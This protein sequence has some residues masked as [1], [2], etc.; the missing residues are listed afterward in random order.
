M[1]RNGIG[2]S[3]PQLLMYSAIGAAAG[4]IG[5]L[6]I[7][8]LLPAPVPGDGFSV[9][10]YDPQWGEKRLDFGEDEKSALQRAITL[11]Q[12][13]VTGVEVIEIRAG[14]VVRVQPAGQPVK[15]VQS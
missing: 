6:A 9:R 14:R 12:Q 5:T 11:G 13:K 2:D 1:S 3:V 10:W 4:A 15:E 7:Q 8:R